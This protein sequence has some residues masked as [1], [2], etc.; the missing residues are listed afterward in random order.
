MT[1]ILR[2]YVRF[3]DFLPV[4]LLLRLLK[5]PKLTRREAFPMKNREGLGFSVGNECREIPFFKK[6][7]WRASIN[8]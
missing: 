7:S 4:F 3:P 8:A 5:F 6:T 2:I 1:T